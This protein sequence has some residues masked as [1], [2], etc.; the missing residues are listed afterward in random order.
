MQWAIFRVVGPMGKGH[1]LWPLGTPDRMLIFAPDYTDPML[2]VF[3]KLAFIRGTAEEDSWAFCLEWTSCH[4]HS[5]NPALFVRVGG[6][7]TTCIACL[8]RVRPGMG[9]HPHAE[10]RRCT[11]APLVGKLRLREGKGLA[12]QRQK[13]GQGAGWGWGGGRRDR[14]IFFIVVCF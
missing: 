6:R 10:G 1:A 9:L 14:V 5:P 11:P 3:Q 13:L 2:H 4:T 7:E 8:R 12:S